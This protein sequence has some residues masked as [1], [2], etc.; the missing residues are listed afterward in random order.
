MPGIAYVDSSALVKLVIAEAETAALRR[1]LRGHDAHATSA[2]S[3]TEVRRAARRV[4]ERLLTRVNAVFRRLTVLS[5]TGDVLESA[6][7]LDPPELRTLD[8]I[9]VASA[10]ALAEDL[11]AFVTYD[12]RQAAAAS[13]LG[14]PVVAPS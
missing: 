12:S 6:A 7:R 9:H 1:A 2:L 11:D 13:A 10:L 4:D 3:S 5:V 8:A 14:L